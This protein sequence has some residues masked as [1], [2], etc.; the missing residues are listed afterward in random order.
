VF[1]PDKVSVEVP[2]LIS[3]PP[4]PPK[5]PPS[6]MFPVT[7]VFTVFPTVSTLDPSLNVPAPAIEPIVMPPDVRP[8][9]SRIPP[10][11]VVRIAF[12]AV[13]EFRNWS[14]PPLLMLRVGAFDELLTIPLPE[15]EKTLV[16]ARV[17]EYAGAPALNWRVPTDALAENVTAVVVAVPKVAIPVGTP[18]DG[19]QLAAVFQSL[20]PGVQVPSCASAAAVLSHRATGSNHPSHGTRNR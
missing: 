12:P 10:E 20:E 17:K 1:V 16:L 18:V 7:T 15:I 3:P 5:E 6:T 2:T 8:D 11:P 14:T 13:L 9:I 19:V 4:A